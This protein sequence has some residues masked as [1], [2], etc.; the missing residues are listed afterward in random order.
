MKNKN[1]NFNKEKLRNGINKAADAVVSTLGPSGRLVA[2]STEYGQSQVTK[3]GVTVLKQIKLKDPEENFGVELLKQN[4]SKVV[5]DAGDGT[6]TTTLLTTELINT[7]LDNIFPSTNV[8]ELRKGIEFATKLIINELE[9]LSVDI[10][11]EKQLQQVATISANGDEEIGKLVSTSIEK[12][13]R[14]GVV[15]VEESRTG[16]TYLDIVEGIQFNTGYKSHYFVTNNDK[17]SCILNDVLILLHEKP[18]TQIEKLL[19]ILE[20]VSTEN[21]S[22]LIIAEEIEGRA[23]A[24]LV[25]NKG[26]GVLKVCAVKAP[27]FGDKRLQNLE[28]IAILTGG[29]VV[30][31]VKGMK[32]EEFD[33]NWFGQARIIN[34]EKDNTTIIDGKGSEE[35]IGKRIIELK[36]QIDNSKSPYEI[37]QLQDRLSKMSGGVAIINIGGKNQTEIKERRDRVDDAICATRAAVEKGILPG[38]GIALIHASKV[39]EKQKPINRD[40]D[41][42]IKL[43][44]DVCNKPFKQILQ[45]TGLSENIVHNKLYSIYSNKDL[46]KGIDVF[47]NE[48][49]NMFDKGIIDPTKVTISCLSNASST[50]IS[51]LLTECIITEEV[52]KENQESFDMSSPF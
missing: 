8:N 51:V 25:V 12:V 15:T 49:I 18:I 32:L 34:I 36:N 27:G 41:L 26:N 2:Y 52:E 30:S 20:K 4:A 13:G 14:D 24:T 7:G 50:A 44:Q 23:L 5:T 37:E 45:N 6:T 17:M 11:N 31:E 35:A 9:N 21:K 22:L 48:K 19:P 42:G 39:L 46:W 33:M 43:I 40:Y 16:E 3:D 28:D 38:G 10:T 29:Q 1:I 47:T